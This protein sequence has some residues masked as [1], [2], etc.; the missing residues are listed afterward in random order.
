[1]QFSI[2]AL[3][4][5]LL[6]SAVW[7]DGTVAFNAK[8]GLKKSK[9][10]KKAKNT[11]APKMREPGPRN[12]N[13]IISKSAARPSEGKIVGS[14]IR[15]F[16]LEFESYV[17]VGYDEDYPA[18]LNE[19]YERCGGML[20]LTESGVVQGH[21]AFRPFNYEGV[22]YKGG[23]TVG[24]MTGD[25]EGLYLAGEYLASAPSSYLNFAQFT[26]DVYGLDPYWGFYQ[27]KSVPGS[28]QFT[29]MK[30]SGWLYTDFCNDD[31][32][33]EWINFDTL[34]TKINTDLRGGMETDA[35][36]IYAMNVDRSRGCEGKYITFI[37]YTGAYNNPKSVELGNTLYG[38]GCPPGGFCTVNGKMY[39]LVDEQ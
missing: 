10:V 38:F 9:K 6:S 11:P 28:S 19:I 24:N 23:C 18:P 36:N 4:A 13:N 16:T 17:G 21:M 3:T 39:E 29:V 35:T 12:R 15:T 31:G 30:G 37:L 20:N 14:L 25:L 34:I 5:A 33:K 8:R 1:M 26:S 2:V 7:A 32:K 27:D 22:D